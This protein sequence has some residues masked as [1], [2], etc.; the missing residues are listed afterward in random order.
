MSARVRKIAEF[1]N[2]RARREAS[3]RIV[4]MAGVE[5]L[6]R[7]GP[8]LMPNDLQLVARTAQQEWLLSIGDAASTS[9]AGS[10]GRPGR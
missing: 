8:Q 9:T 10:N 1:G 7:E 2:G 6:V 3:V 5:K 4:C